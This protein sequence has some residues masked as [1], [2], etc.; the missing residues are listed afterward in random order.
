MLIIAG[1]GIALIVIAMLVSGS[2]S[3][4][5]PTS[6]PAQRSTPP[7]PPSPQSG[8]L[9][10][11]QWINDQLSLEL[12]SAAPASA[13]QRW[14]VERSRLDNVAIG[15]Q[16]QFLESGAP[17]WQPLGQ[18]MSALATALDTNLGLRSQ[19]T[20]DAALIAQSTDVVNRHRAEVRQLITALW[21]TIQR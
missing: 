8:L 15:A 4:S 20:P 21:P 1:V 3:K 19:P 14:S 13:A 16:Q 12:M 2:K 9:S 6:R 10:T 17:N 18:A 11:A 7:L 5:T